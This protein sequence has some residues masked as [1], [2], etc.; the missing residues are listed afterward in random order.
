MG[1][2]ESKPNFDFNKYG[3]SADQ[4]ANLR[5]Y[6][7]RAAGHTHKL[8]Y[9]KFKNFYRILNQNADENLVTESAKKAFKEADTD[10]DGSIGFDEFAVYYMLQYCRA[11]YPEEKKE[12]EEETQF[13]VIKEE[14]DPEMEAKRISIFS[15]LI[16]E[17]R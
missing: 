4:T 6:F 14:N 9:Q 15:E 2:K 3:L 17:F 7:N 5:Q 16:E 13:D 8:S 10:K 12:I 1:L 11:N